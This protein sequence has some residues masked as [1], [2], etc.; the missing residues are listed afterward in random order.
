MSAALGTGKLILV[1]V[2]TGVAPGLIRSRYQV[3]SCV[4]HSMPPRPEASW[5]ESSTNVRSSAAPVTPTNVLPVGGVTVASRLP[6]SV[7]PTTTESGRGSLT[8]PLCPAGGSVP[9]V[10]RPLMATK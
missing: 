8:V 5:T 2:A 9:M 7:S 10:C 3:R 6:V 1:T 4:V